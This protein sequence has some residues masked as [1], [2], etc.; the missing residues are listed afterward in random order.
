MARPG[1]PPHGIEPAMTPMIEV[2]GARVRQARV[3]RRMTGKAVMAEM[4]W[5]GARQTRLEQSEVTMLDRESFAR[6]VQVLRFPPGFFMTAPLSR[7]EP[8]QLLFRAPKSTSSTEKEYL[9]SFAASVGDFLHQ[10]NE[11]WQLPPVRL[12]TLRRDTSV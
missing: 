6:L 7:V 10:L 4:G 12:P 8:S 2:F 3:L 11:R 5:K 1:W 9:A